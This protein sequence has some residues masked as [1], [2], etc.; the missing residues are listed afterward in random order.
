MGS[1]EKISDYDIVLLG[2]SKSD[3]ETEKYINL[4]NPFLKIFTLPIK[5]HRYHVGERYNHTTSGAVGY[6]INK[7]GKEKILDIERNFRLA[8]DWKILDDLGLRI[9]Y[10]KPTVIMEDIDMNSSL[11]HKQY[12]I[13]PLK[14][15]FLL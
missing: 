6:F 7:K 11:N 4:I 13:R 10:L 12:F 2:F 14:T 3:Y 9:G 1:I 5:N 8:D 15:N